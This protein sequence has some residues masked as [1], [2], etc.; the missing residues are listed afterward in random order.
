MTQLY[1]SFKTGVGQGYTSDLENGRR[2]ETTA[3][4]KKIAD[5]MNVPLDILV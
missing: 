1:L 4:L 3:A 5:A 2:K